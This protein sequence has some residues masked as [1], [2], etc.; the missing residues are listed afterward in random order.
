MLMVS[1]ADDRIKDDDEL[2]ASQRDEHV[3][4]EHDTNKAGILS[5]VW[6]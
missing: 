3:C 6:K 4:V 1:L 5:L 2:E